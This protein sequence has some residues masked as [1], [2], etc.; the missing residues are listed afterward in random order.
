MNKVHTCRQILSE[1]RP[2]LYGENVFQMKMKSGASN[3]RYGPCARSYLNSPSWIICIYRSMD[4]A[5]S[6]LNQ[7]P[8]SLKVLSYCAMFAVSFSM[9]FH[10]FMRNIWNAR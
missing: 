3:Q 4:V 6:T 5:V 7:L 10:Q 8:M 2:I 9:E 1:S